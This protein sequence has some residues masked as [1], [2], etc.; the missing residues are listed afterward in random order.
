MQHTA[1]DAKNRNT[2]LQRNGNPVIELHESHGPAQNSG[3]NKIKRRH[4]MEKNLFIIITPCFNE[5]NYIECLLR[6]VV[7]QTVKPVK[8]IIVD[9]GSTDNTARIVQKYA[10]QYEWIEYLYNSKK[11][12]ETYYSSNVYAILAGY[13]ALK[14]LE[15]SGSSKRSKT[16]NSFDY[17]AILDSD[18]EICSTYYEEIFEK[19]KNYPELGIATGTYLEKEDENWIEARID[20]RSTP[21]A[22]QVFRRECYEQCGGYIPFRFGGEDSGIE[23][24]ARMHGWQTWSFNDILVKHLRPVGTGNGQALLK[25]RFKIGYIEHAMATH[26]LFMFFKCIKRAF[27]EK[28]IILSGLARFLGYIT[29]KIL[30]LE[31]QLPREAMKY[32][33]CEQ[34]N[35]LLNTINLGKKMW[36][37]E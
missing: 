29:A 23:I 30:R 36:Y 32:L 35:R 1:L 27:W 24:I 11:P 6:S 5:E 37:P 14:E 12:G 33:R 26:P 4:K 9:D 2:V 20:R 28:P 16:G 31:Q 15:N 34:I 7:K 10:K 19:F 21:K 8:W 25:S 18:I 13:E 22:I 3:M 17:I